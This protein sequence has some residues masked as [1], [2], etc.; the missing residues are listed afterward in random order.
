MISLAAVNL[1]KLRAATAAIRAVQPENFID[2]AQPDVAA[3]GALPDIYHVVFDELQVNLFEAELTD[4]IRAQLKGLIWFRNATTPYGRTAMALSSLFSGVPYDYREPAIDY[5]QRAFHSPQS[6]LG[7]LKSMGYQTIGF[8]HELFPRRSAVP[9]DQIY[10]HEEL[11]KIASAGESR[12]MFAAVWFYGSLPRSISRRLI[13]E[14]DFTQLQ[15]HTLLPR[16]EA[17]A[18]VQSFR[19]FMEW[20][21]KTHRKGGRYI[22]I[23]LLLPHGP[24]VVGRDCAYHETVT[25]ADQVACSVHEL[26]E[27][28]QFLDGQG[29]FKDAL[30]ILHGDHGA[31]MVDEGGTLVEA[32]DHY[33]GPRYSSLRSRPAVLI[34]PAGVGRTRELQIDPRP[35]DLFD[36][37]PTVLASLGRPMP[38]GLIGHSLLADAGPARPRFYHFFELDPERILR[39]TIKRYRIVGDQAV[40][41]EEISVPE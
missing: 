15:N 16:R 39:G 9:Y 27:F 24:F 18:S 1:V 14:G 12:S 11:Q 4:E 6:L 26:V 40:F 33:Y 37:Y 28:L 36:L 8:V 23:H 30:L 25:P 31:G 41:D 34:K 17:F 7:Q 10:R 20:E 32:Q 22:F 3:A 38:A 35:M 5:V 21:G 2:L 19:R 29:R 13:R